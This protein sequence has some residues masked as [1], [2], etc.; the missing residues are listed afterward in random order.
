MR[1]IRLGQFATAHEFPAAVHIHT[2]GIQQIISLLGT[3]HC[4]KTIINGFVM[5][6]TLWA[7]CKCKLILK[8][9]DI[10][11]Q[12]SQA[13]LTSIRLVLSLFLNSEDSEA[14]ELE[15]AA[16]ESGG[17]YYSISQHMTNQVMI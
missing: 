15:I 4:C 9:D 5:K 13:N 1:E 6:H 2:D 10:L 11:Q 7:D 16:T 17:L 14:H 8:L 3:T 12:R